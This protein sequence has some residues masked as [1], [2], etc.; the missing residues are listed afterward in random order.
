MEHQ[1]KV[2]PG[3]PSLNTEFYAKVYEEAFETYVSA[4]EYILGVKGVETKIIEHPLFH[5]LAFADRISIIDSFIKL[6][7]RTDNNS[8]LTLQFETKHEKMVI[9]V[10]RSEWVQGRLTNVQR[11]LLGILQFDIKAAM[12]HC[13][14]TPNTV[15]RLMDFIRIYCKR[16]EKWL[17]GT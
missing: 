5:R 11:Q 13:E 15:K 1:V 16:R 9:Y 3:H 14:H 12:L 10:K 4:F 7:L 8:D 6:V 2:S 17:K